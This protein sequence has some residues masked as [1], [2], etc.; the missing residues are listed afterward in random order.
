MKLRITPRAHKD[1]FGILEYIEQNNCTE[2]AE[3]QVNKIYETIEF[4][5][6]NP[7]MGKALEKLDGNKTEYRTM[8]IRPYIA[9]YVIAKDCVEIIRV[10]DGRRDYLR[11]LEIE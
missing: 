11:I 6:E 8:T 3:K 10:L 5:K 1:I 2:I 4:L 7:Y 9:F